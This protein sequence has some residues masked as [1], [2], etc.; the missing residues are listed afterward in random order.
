[1]PMAVAARSIGVGLRPLADWDCGF[2]S[3]RGHGCLSLVIVV[4]CHVEVS[5]TG[6]SLVQSRPTECACV[7]ES[8]QTQQ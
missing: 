6:R 7:I 3:R 8:D 2:E 4:Y 5:E 1:M